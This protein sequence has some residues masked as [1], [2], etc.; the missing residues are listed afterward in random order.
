[1]A[2]YATQRYNYW[3][4]LGIL[5]AFVGGG[6]IIGAIASFLPLMDKIDFFSMKGG[7]ATEMMNKI[8]VPENANALRWSQFLSTLFL[9]FVP[10]V[11]YAYVC[12]KKP[13]LH[14]GFQKKFDIKEFLLVIFIMLACLPIVSAL[15]EVTEMYPWSKAALA[16]FKEAEDAYNKQV[17][18]MARMNSFFEYIVSVI[19]IALLPAVF[20]EVLFRGALQNLLSRWFKMPILAIVVTSI[21][22]SAIHGSYLGFLSRFALGFILGWMY[23]RTGNIWLNIVAHFVNNAL[24]VTALYIMT[25]PGEKVDPSVMDESS[26]WWLVLVSLA[27]LGGLL[28]LFEKVIKKDIDRPGEEVL[29]PGYNLSNDP[30][31]NDIAT[32]QTPNPPFN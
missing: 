30:F 22:F 13:F 19:I 17:A 12:H 24:A 6:L 1:M 25:K 14:L 21:I 3:G 9:F 32:Q 27:A 4:Q 20:E 28:V 23:Y 18:V 10:C 8:L 15:Q 16:R 5:A 2:H 11:L 26:P 7:S 29:I 31:A